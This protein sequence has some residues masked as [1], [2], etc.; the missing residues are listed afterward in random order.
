MLQI[1]PELTEVLTDDSGH[2]LTK[3]TQ[4]A[5][6]FVLYHNNLRK[7]NTQAIPWH[8]HEE[9]ELSIMRAGSMEFEYC[10]TKLILRPG[11][12][13]FINTG[14]LHAMRVNKDEPCEYVSLLFNSEIISGSAYSAIHHKYVAPVTG[15]C[16]LKPLLFSIEMAQGKEIGAHVNAIESKW[17]SDDYDREMQIRGRLSDIWLKILDILD[18]CHTLPYAP[19]DEE[20][21]KAV[22]AYINENYKTGIMLPELAYSTGM[23]L[24]TLHRKFKSCTGI[25]VGEYITRFK[26]SRAANKLAQPGVS[27]TDACYECGFND[28]SYFTKV[29]KKIIG[30]TPSEFSKSARGTIA[31]YDNVGM[32][33]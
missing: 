20:P 21:I 2:E 6:P 26:V 17:Y 27:A 9:C 11:D 19:F 24:S 31:N 14:A 1:Y 16:D 3:H 8:W 10:G 32:E 22:L 15:N 33:D 18:A 30:K 25:S 12:G 13:Y 5:F 29:F 23:S 28:L 7:F 4:I